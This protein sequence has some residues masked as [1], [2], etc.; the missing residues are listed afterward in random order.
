MVILNGFNE[1]TTQDYSA[2]TV[3]VSYINRPSGNWFLGSLLSSRHIV[4]AAN[5][6]FYRRS[7]PSHLEVAAGLGGNQSDFQF[8]GVE[9]I[10]IPNEYR[11]DKLDYDIA[12]LI[13]IECFR[14]SIYVHPIQLNCIDPTKR[15]FNATSVI[16]DDIYGT[17][18]E[19]VKSR[20]EI[21]CGPTL[22]CGTQNNDE[23]NKI[24]NRDV[25]TDLNKNGLIGI[26]IYATD[27]SQFPN[28]F[29]NIFAV[30]DWLSKESSGRFKC[31]N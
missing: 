19:L 1:I 31:K 6:I 5:K 4:T 30:I 8:R 28:I 17:P 26:L 9:D 21:D 2:H 29:T 27:E 12:L 15:P 7:I 3:I 10:K 13:L 22:I 18:F 16:N 20:L 14:T 24:D 23:R 25:G 11:P